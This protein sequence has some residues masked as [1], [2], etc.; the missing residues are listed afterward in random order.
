[1]GLFGKNQKEMPS[2]PELPELKEVK[3][4]KREFSL[5][6]LPSLPSTSLGE[7]FSRNMIKEAVTGGKEEIGG[8]NEF[9]RGRMMHSPEIPRTREIEES[10][11]PEQFMPAMKRVKDKEPIFIRIDKFEESLKVLE[12][13]KNKIYEI[14]RVLKEIRET[15][16]K[17]ERELTAWE[18]EIQKI[19][20]QIERVDS[21]IF[22]KVE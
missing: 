15:K 3:K 5:P 16:E 19:K 18:E 17:E 10:Y 9:E 6:Q 12:N 13:T 20:Q 4:E 1:M 22:S 8:A 7:K 2:L 21:E 14:E 11:V